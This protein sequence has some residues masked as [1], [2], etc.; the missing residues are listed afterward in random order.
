VRPPRLNEARFR[1]KGWRCLAAVLLA[2]AGLFGANVAVAADAKAADAK[3]GGAHRFEVDRGDRTVPPA[4]RR[5]IAARR[6]EMP[7]GVVVL[8]GSRPAI[9]PP[10]PYV[11]E[12]ALGG[13]GYGSTA[14]GSP[15]IAAAPSAV[16]L[17]NVGGYDFS[18]LDPPVIGVFNLDQ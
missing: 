2:V 7:P 16:D 4:A 11:G 17:G 1:I 3:D 8:R 9:P 15:D 10:Y 6:S 5:G 12:P 18:G 14:D 13:E